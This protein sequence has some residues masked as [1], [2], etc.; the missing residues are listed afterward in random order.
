MYETFNE[1]LDID[2]KHRSDAPNITVLGLI[3]FVIIFILM[4]FSF[5]TFS[6]TGHFCLEF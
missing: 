1:Y 2:T 6:N 3:F 4:I 5:E